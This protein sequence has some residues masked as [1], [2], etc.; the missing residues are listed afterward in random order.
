MAA[1]EKFNT[2]KTYIEFFNDGHLENMQINLFPGSD[3]PRL[4]FWDS[5]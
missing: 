5:T 1:V 4:F 2:L 3:D